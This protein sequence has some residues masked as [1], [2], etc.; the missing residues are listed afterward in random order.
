MSVAIIIIVVSSVEG[1]KHKPHGGSIQGSIMNAFN[2]MTRRDGAHA[3]TPIGDELPQHRYV[4]MGSDKPDTYHY[5]MGQAPQGFKP[6]VQPDGVR[7]PQGKQMS[8]FDQH[9]LG[10]NSEIDISSRRNGLGANEELNL[11]RMPQGGEWWK[12]AL[13]ANQEIDI[14]SRRHGLGSSSSE[15]NLSRLPM[16]DSNGGPTGVE[17]NSAYSTDYNAAPG[18]D[19]YVDYSPDDTSSGAPMFS[20]SAEA[21]A[22]L[23]SD[24]YGDSYKSSDNAEDDQVSFIGTASPTSV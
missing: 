23:L 10:A 4:R 2:T 11:S 20:N 12:K 17:L 21:G 19:G 6:Y 5:R 7:G 15:Y 3:P 16:G 13:G 8:W 14:S 9:H 22:Q 18:A 24:V 1:T